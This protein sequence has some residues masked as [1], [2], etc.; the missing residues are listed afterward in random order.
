MLAFL[1]HRIETQ[2]AKLSDEVK[3]DLRAHAA[4]AIAKRESEVGPVRMPVAK[5]LGSRWPDATKPQKRRSAGT[6]AARSRNPRR[7]SSPA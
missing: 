2:M 1:D 5:P 4:E 7:F 6:R 3:A